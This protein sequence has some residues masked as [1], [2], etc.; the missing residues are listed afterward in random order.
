[1]ALTK[2]VQVPARDVPLSKKG[3]VEEAIN[4]I[5]PEMFG[6][7]GDGVYDDA[8]AIQAAVA[9]AESI[10][11]GV[12]TRA[13][14][15]AIKF[16]AK[17]YYLNQT[18]K[19]RKGTVRWEGAG[20]YQ[21]L[22]T[23]HPDATS[24][25]MQFK[26]FFDFSSESW[27]SN[28]TRT[29]HEV[30]LSGF[31]FL[32]NG[33]VRRPCMYLGGVGWDCVFDTV[34][35]YSSGLSAIVADDLFDTQFYN[36]RINS[37]GRLHDPADSADIFTHAVMFRGKYD[38][39]NAIRFIAP[40]FEANSGGVISITGRSNNIW[41]DGAKFENNSRTTAAGASYP[42]VQLSGALIDSIKFI[43]PFVSHPAATV[44]QWFLDSN[45]R[46]VEII[47][48]S[49]M[50]PSD[51]SG[52][53]CERWFNIHRAGWASATRCV[54]LMASISMMHVNGAATMGDAPIKLYNDAILSIDAPRVTDPN[55]FIEA[56]YDCDININYLTLLG[57]ITPAQQTALFNVVASDAKVNVDVERTVGNISGIIYHNSDMSAASRRK[58]KATI[59]A[60]TAQGSGTLSEGTDTF[61]YDEG[62]VWTAS[63]VV[64]NLPA[65]HVGK[66]LLVRC[67]DTSN[68]LATGGNV[69]LT[70]AIT[71]ACTVVLQ[72]TNF[73]FRQGWMEVSRLT[74]V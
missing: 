2:L 12:S 60:Q 71:G 55:K 19:V 48:G 42:V 69:F 26:Y 50:S 39:C 14:R 51:L 53:T 31:T 22:F 27:V 64:Q 59:R 68:C 17:T 16:A 10:N 5:T 65:C 9:Y 66:Q 57:S 1:M 74:G 44:S 23:P 35:F 29:L 56:G 54:G 46:N 70:S 52:Y 40:H 34:H 20:M 37:C 47:G 45:A 43:S 25:A 30:H 33:S 28:A 62:Y 24:A 6:A 7:K 36:I 41:F 4:W 58:S 13:P 61:G 8:I 38:N 18:I 32:G 72:S 3:S 49:F 63:G 73:S 67:P 15:V 11:S 21:T